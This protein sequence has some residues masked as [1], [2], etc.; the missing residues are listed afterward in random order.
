MPLTGPGIPPQRSVAPQRRGR[1]PLSSACSEDAS[2]SVE[3]ALELALELAAELYSGTT[4][5]ETP[6]IDHPRA[7]KTRGSHSA[8]PEWRDGLKAQPAGQ[9]TEPG[10]SRWK[11]VTSW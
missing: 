9:V 1:G 3:S 7:R 8:G 4:A 5:P 6:A 10:R 2:P 11:S